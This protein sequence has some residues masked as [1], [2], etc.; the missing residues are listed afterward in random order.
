MK[1]VSGIATQPTDPS[2][3][4][5]CPDLAQWPQRWHYEERDLVPGQALVDAFT[6]FL[7]HLLSS[8]LARKTLRRHRDN[9]WRLGGEIIRKIQQ[10]P[11]L[12]H[13]SIV[14]ILILLDEINDVWPAARS[15]RD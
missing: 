15:A 10:E 1:T 11:E 8:E 3:A 7:L 6:P 14:A 12:R 9:L 13:R 5:Y 2:L 4:A